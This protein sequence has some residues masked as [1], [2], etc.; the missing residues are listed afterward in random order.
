V[1]VIKNRT[2]AGRAWIQ[3]ILASTTRVDRVDIDN[4]TDEHKHHQSRTVDLI[5]RFIEVDGKD[6]ELVEVEPRR[7]LYFTGSPSNR[8]VIR[9]TLTT[10]AFDVSDLPE[11]PEGGPA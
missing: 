6:A 2:K 5:R 3:T 7:Y 9:Y 1:K 8:Y 10:Y 4:W 11:L